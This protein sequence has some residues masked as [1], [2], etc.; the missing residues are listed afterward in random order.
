MTLRDVMKDCPHRKGE[1]VLDVQPMNHLD[2][3]AKHLN[4]YGKITMH[5]TG[6]QHSDRLNDYCSSACPSL[7]E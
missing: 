1:V 2:K 4:K 3:L 7:M 5:V 6:C